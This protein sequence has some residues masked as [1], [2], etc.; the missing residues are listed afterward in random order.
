[1]QAPIICIVRCHGLTLA[2]FCQLCQSFKPPLFG[3]LL[4]PDSRV[5][6]K[7]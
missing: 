7:T 3:V 5:N 6:Q 4:C 1:M 2:S